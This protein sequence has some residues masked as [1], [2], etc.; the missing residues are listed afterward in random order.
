[1]S[2]PL[3][4]CSL[5]DT[6]TRA[7][8]PEEN[9]EDLF[10][11]DKKTSDEGLI[12]TQAA[13]F[14]HHACAHDMSSH[15]IRRRLKSQTGGMADDALHRAAISRGK[16]LSPLETE[17][18]DETEHFDITDSSTGVTSTTGT[19]SSLDVRRTV[20]TLQLAIIVFYSVSGGPFGIEEAVRSAGPFFCL[21]G[22]LIG[23]LVWSIPEAAMTAEL[24]S[25]YPDASGGV[26]WVE[27]AFGA[28]AGWC[29]GFLAF[30]SGATDTAIYPILFLDYVMQ[31]V[32]TEDPHPWLQYAAVSIF[33]MVLSYINYTGLPVVGNL[34][35]VICALSMSPFIIAF[36]LGV[37]KVEP[38][39]WF[40]L[41]KA[42]VDMVDD[43]SSS[44]MSRLSLS[45]ILWRPFLN[46]LFWNLNSF[47][48]AA[49]FS[50]EVD[51][52]GRSFPRAMLW[53]VLLVAS[54]YILPL[55]IVLG[56]SDAPQSAWVDGY[57]AA[58]IAEVDGAWLEAWLVFA[59]GITNI[60]LF[61]AEMASDA[62]QVMGMA[63]RGY[64]PRIFSTRSQYGT[65]TYGI[66]LGLSI[67][68]LMSV[69]NL[70]SL[71]EL[72]NFNY[73]M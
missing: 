27:E 44:W 20:G 34:S 14:K 52:P 24:G 26:V 60:A 29:C 15:G 25:A 47:D 64:L 69:T 28:R 31:V 9:F 8:K 23:P 10:S 45:G 19:G 53:S 57:L 40:Q 71:I 5:I 61:Q 22:F 2:K 50:A 21:V 30:V 48:S 62:F 41:P 39:R 37:W 59:A 55:L 66:L 63:D 54:S 70:E 33:A 68:L 7:N 16:P 11:H 3:S 51:D 38:H 13:S 4:F 65:P 17:L 67:V 12:L 46:N 36:L 42:S 1:M 6:A 58:A 56:V 43:N 35:T 49:S 18:S 73:A 72:L 32:N